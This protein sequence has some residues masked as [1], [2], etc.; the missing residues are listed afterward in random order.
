VTSKDKAAD[1]SLRRNYGITLEE[2]EA[3]LAA[4]GGGCAICGSV[5]KQRRLHT[6]HDHKVPKG[7][8]LT[9]KSL[10]MAVNACDPWVAEAVVGSKVYS[11]SAGRKHLAIQSLRKYMK[12]ASVRGILCWPCNR[13]LRVFCNDPDR[14][15]AAAKYLREYKE[16]GNQLG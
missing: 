4:Q 2:Y 7:K 11:A 5:A 9:H 10:T 15:E 14:L 8:I 1:A 13:A 12:R 16:K 6:D 3:M